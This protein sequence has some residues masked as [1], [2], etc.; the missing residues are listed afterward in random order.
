MNI[1]QEMSMEDF[2]ELENHMKSDKALEKKAK[3]LVALMNCVND[4]ADIERC[5]DVLQNRL[6][7]EVGLI[8]PSLASIDEGMVKL[9]KDVEAADVKHVCTGS[10]D[11]TGNKQ[12]EVAAHLPSPWYRKES[13]KHAGKFYY[14][15][16]ITGE[17][18]WKRPAEP[19][20]TTSMADPLAAMSFPKKEV[21]ATPPAVIR[22]PPG[23]DAPVKP[24][25]VVRPP[26]GFAPKV[27]YSGYF[28]DYSTDAGLTDCATDYDSDIP[29]PFARSA[30]V[31]TKAPPQASA[32][33]KQTVLRPS[34]PEFQPMATSW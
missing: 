12:K 15:H 13:S 6:G 33:W 2:A 22:A 30:Y 28:S 3:S 5:V 23:L 18:S 10:D 4:L 14:V 8:G 29:R 1:L 16:K 21:L 32:D 25:K 27:S 26:P 31:T 11:I 20:E 24:L 19:C 34:A 17:T 7:S 9:D